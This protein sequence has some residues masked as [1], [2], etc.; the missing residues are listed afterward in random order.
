MLLILR[1]CMNKGKQETSSLSSP[2]RE[3][4]PQGSADPA[5]AAPAEHWARP[6][7]QLGRVPGS[8]RTPRAGGTAVHQGG[9][10]GRARAPACRAKV[11]ASPGS[12]TSPRAESRGRR[13]F[14]L[15]A[16]HVFVNKSL[17]C[18]LLGFRLSVTAQ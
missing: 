18:A 12:S 14:L 15:N 10:P 1:R 13:R 16:M 2:C 3:P 4:L 7:G 11:G 5:W 8:S 9:R 6:W 17:P